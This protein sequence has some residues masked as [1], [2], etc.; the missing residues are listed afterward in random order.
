[1]CYPKDDIQS[2]VTL[3]TVSYPADTSRHFRVL[4]SSIVARLP[5]ALPEYES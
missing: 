5:G 1:V 3:E 4:P 2:G